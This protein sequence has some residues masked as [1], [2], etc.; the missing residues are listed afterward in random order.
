MALHEASTSPACI[1]K[2]ASARKQIIPTLVES[3]DEVDGGEIVVTIT[4]DNEDCQALLQENKSLK[5]KL[6]KLQRR[7]DIA[8]K[9]L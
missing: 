1:P 6:K 5:D 3:D 9:K 2:P 7:L 8:G 4:C